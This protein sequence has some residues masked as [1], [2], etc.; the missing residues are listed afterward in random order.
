METSGKIAKT[1]EIESFTSQEVE[2]A[3]CRF[4][5]DAARCRS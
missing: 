2:A 4:A 3:T 1:R 5:E